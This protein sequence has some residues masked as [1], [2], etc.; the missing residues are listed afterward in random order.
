MYMMS[1]SVFS[2]AGFLIF[3]YEIFE[4]FFFLYVLSAAELFPEVLCQSAICCLVKVS[5]CFA[6]INIT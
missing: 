5:G 6:I 1:S 3:V 2:A 4:F